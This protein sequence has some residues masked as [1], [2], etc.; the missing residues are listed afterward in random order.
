MST[1]RTFI[2]VPLPVDVKSAMATVQK[3]L[4]ASGAEATW[5][6]DDKFH[7]T[8]KF[9]GATDSSLIPNIADRLKKSIGSF[10]AFELAYVKLGAF[11][12]VDHPRVMW[13]GTSE[14][15]EIVRLQSL[16]DEV[17]ISLGFAKEDRRFH[18][19]I[20][21]GRVKG[22]RNLERLTASLKSITFEPLLARCTE[23]HIV[24]SDLK[25]TGP[26]YTLLNTISL[27][28]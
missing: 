12:N 16:V 10:P 13:I 21:L 14:S 3:Q 28:S 1:I 25:P 24:R 20:T 15:Q 9:L 5:D 4:V 17:C 11:P 18:A 19:H 23:V 22:I 8:L 26:V 7:I 27:A 2:A 6:H